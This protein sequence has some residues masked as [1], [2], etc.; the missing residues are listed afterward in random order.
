MKLFPTQYLEWVV[1]FDLEIRTRYDHLSKTDF[2]NHLV[3]LPFF[4]RDRQS[5]KP[6]MRPT[7][8]VIGSLKTLKSDS[9]F[10]R[11]RN[12]SMNIT[13]SENGLNSSGEWMV[14]LS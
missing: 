2:S 3:F 5:L 10:V 4:K 12:S 9:V 13:N 8:N 14:L 7:R 11:R 6:P 1:V